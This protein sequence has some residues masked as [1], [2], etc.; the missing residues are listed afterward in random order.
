MMFFNLFYDYNNNFF[1]C[2]A[3]AST[4]VDKIGSGDTFMAFFVLAN[5]IFS[6]D[7]ELSLFIASIATIQV[8]EGF[9][10]EKTVDLVTLLKSINYILK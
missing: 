3:F 10:N 9:A 7:I 8:L 1:Y 6:N 2:P 5:R 4:A